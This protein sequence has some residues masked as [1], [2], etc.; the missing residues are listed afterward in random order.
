MRDFV[1]EEI[2]VGDA[3]VYP[4]RKG[5]RLVMHRGTVTDVVETGVDTFGDPQPYIVV[6][7]DRGD[8]TVSVK[9]T[10]IDNVVVLV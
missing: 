4:Y 2:M 5:S 8:Y 7:K 3:V 9:I 1:G 10:R 6:D